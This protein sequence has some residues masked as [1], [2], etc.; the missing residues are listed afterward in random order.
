MPSAP[1]CPDA[2][3]ALRIRH[4]ERIVVFSGAGMSAESGIATFRDPIHGLWS[5]FSPSELAT[6]EAWRARRTTV[7]AWYEWRRSQVLHAEPH[8]GHRAVAALVQAGVASVVTQNFDDL[9][10]RAGASDVV[11]L[12]GSL[13]HGR[14][15]ACHRPHGLAPTAATTEPVAEL[16]PPRCTHCGGWVRPAVVWFGESLPADAWRLAEQRIGQSDLLIIVGTSGVVQPAA[17]LAQAAPDDGVILEI[18]P[19]PAADAHPG[20]IVWRSTAAQALPVLAERL[21]RPVS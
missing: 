9:H 14:C 15:S 10:E 17:S 1:A 21:L 12:H 5:R 3:D 19:E 4:F 6:P 7:W 20:R 13:M 18:N 8:A 16:T 11:H 2:V